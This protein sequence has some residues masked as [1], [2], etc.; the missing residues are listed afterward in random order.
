MS[1]SEDLD[2]KNIL[3]GSG[4]KWIGDQHLVSF[5]LLPSF[6]EFWVHGYFFQMFLDEASSELEVNVFNILFKMISSVLICKPN[7][8]LVYRSFYYTPMT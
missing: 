5:L 3:S 7:R 8:N 6:L 2:L 1:V 4:S